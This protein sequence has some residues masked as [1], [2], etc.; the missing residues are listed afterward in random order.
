MKNKIIAIVEA[1]MSSK[2]LPGKVML[3]IKNETILSIL[4]NRIK[5]SK[6]I[7]DI[8]V[9]TTKNSVDQKI[10]NFCAKSKINCFR[11]SEQNVTSRVYNCAKKF[12]ANIIVQLTGDNPLIDYRI[13]DRAIS[14][15][16]KNKFDFVTNNNFGDYN[17]KTP[18]GMIVSVFRK[19]DLK[20]NLKFCKTK[21]LK[22]HSSL[23]FYREGKN[24]YKIKNFNTNFNLFNGTKPR[25]TLDYNKDLKLI[26]KI[27]IN[28]SKKYSYNFSYKSIIQFLNSN[29]KLLK[30]N[31]FIKQK[32]PKI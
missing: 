23:F 8:V 9:A 32:K 4:I 28:L 30:I 3:K 20:K 26:K 13:I 10:V 25:L 27:Y 2:R 7:D 12:N 5:N 21:A 19:S 17:D 15:F 18:N 24:K 22:E 14:I 11:G 1:R 31:S 6:Q 29:K 16:K